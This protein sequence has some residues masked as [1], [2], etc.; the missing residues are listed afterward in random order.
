MPNTL[1]HLGV[2]LAA[3]QASRLLGRDVDPRWVMTGCVVP[4]VP[5]IA[6]RAVRVLAPGVDPFSLRL[7]AVAQSSLAVSLLLCGALA[8]LTRAPRRVFAVLA[9]M[10]LLHLLLDA[11]QTKWGNGVHLLAPFS[12]EL[13]NWGL[14]W[15][16]SPVTAA[17][18]LFGALAAGVALWQLHS[19]AARRTGWRLG[20]TPLAVAAALGSAWVAAPWLLREGPYRADN[21]SVRTLMERDARVGRPVAF[22]RASLVSEDGRAR[23]HSFDGEALDLRGALPD[24][25]A[26]VSLRG[27]FRGPDLVEVDALHVHRG[28]PRDAA[29]YLGLSLVAVAWLVPPRRAAAGP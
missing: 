29:S 4:D 2:G 16:E 24:A 10:S 11:C 14:F 27:H 12:W 9:S 25:P 23:V 15:P 13:W 17:L 19:G 26:Q 18:T 22:D 1:A 6:A 8:A 7:Y 21:H 20:A 28:W 3:S 5:W